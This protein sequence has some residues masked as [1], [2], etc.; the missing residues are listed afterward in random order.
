MGHYESCPSDGLGYVSALR[1]LG[2]KFVFQQERTASGNLHFQIRVSLFHK[3]SLSG[4]VELLQGTLLQGAHVSKTSGVNSKN[5]N[6]VMKKDSR[7]DGPWSDQED[8]PDDIDTEL[9]LPP[10]RWQEDCIEYIKGPI[11]P[12]KIRVYVDIDGGSGKSWVMSKLRHLKLATII[13]GTMEKAEDISAMIMCKPA[14]R[15][16]CVDLPRSIT[17]KKMA[18]FWA[19]LEVI[20]NGYCSDKRNKFR[21]RVFKKPHLVVFMNCEPPLH[22]MSADRWDIIRL[23]KGQIVVL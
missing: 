13:P 15:A 12:R 1:P 22:A 20:K 17:P 2:K 14:D 11:N 7:V 8:D 18:S 5:F 6:Y 23:S 10:M 4:M 19:G 16:Y 3:K 9:L 21:D